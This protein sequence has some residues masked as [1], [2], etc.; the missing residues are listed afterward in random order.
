M[1][2]REA[3]IKSIGFQPSRI[4]NIG[5]DTG[6]EIREGREIKAE[7]NKIIKQWLDAV[8]ASDRAKVVASM[9]EFN[10]RVPERQRLSLKFLNNIRNKQMQ[11]YEVE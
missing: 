5:E 2:E 4:A 1:T 10:A 7:K 6:R 9:R 3:V 11:K 8:S